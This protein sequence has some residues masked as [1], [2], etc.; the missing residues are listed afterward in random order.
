MPEFVH[1]YLGNAA[2]G[3]RLF[4]QSA[5]G[6]KLVPVTAE[7]TLDAPFSNLAGIVDNKGRGMAFVTSFTN[8]ESF[9]FWGSKSNGEQF[10]TVEAFQGKRPVGPE[11]SE[12]ILN[13]LVP[14]TGVNAPA[15]ASAEGVGGFTL[16]GKKLEF[17]F[18]AAGNEKITFKAAYAARGKVFASGDL[19]KAPVCLDA[20]WNGGSVVVELFCGSRSIGKAWFCG[21]DNFKV[22]R[23]ARTVVPVAKPE[24]ENLDLNFVDASR[25]GGPEVRISNHLK[26]APVIWFAGTKFYWAREVPEFIRRY[27]IKATVFPLG[28]TWVNISSTPPIAAIWGHQ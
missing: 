28:G 6:A 17:N 8:L 24:K 20:N 14:F 15:F 1:S 11:K 5:K 12:T 26:G 23:T 22:P 27:G 9:V 7:L 16:T 10:F 21:K 18:N 3:N 13:Y 4:I 19:G 25:Q 2:G